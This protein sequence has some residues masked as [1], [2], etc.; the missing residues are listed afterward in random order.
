MVPEPSRH[1]F[2]AVLSVVIVA[3]LVHVGTRD[4]PGR[5]HSLGVIASDVKISCRGKEDRAVFRRADRYQTWVRNS[6]PRAR[7]SPDFQFALSCRWEVARV[8]G[9]L[10]GH[11]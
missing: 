7:R 11:K 9:W 8:F 6:E 4:F 5:N 10:R 3:I 1:L 2:L